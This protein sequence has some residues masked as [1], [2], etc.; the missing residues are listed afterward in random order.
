MIAAKEDL[1]H[2]QKLASDREALAAIAQQK[3]EAT[4]AIQRSEAAQAAQNVIQAQQRLAAS[5]AAVA[6]HQKI[7]ASIEIQRTENEAAKLSKLQRNEE[8]AALHHVTASKY[9][10][11][12]S[13]INRV[14][15]PQFP[16]NPWT[17]QPIHSIHGWPNPPPASNIWNPAKPTLLWG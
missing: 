13:G 3:S 15:T 8:A 14:N 16:P 11:L 12:N 5:K 1:I 4:A 17:Q 9:A 10:A 7:A 2:Q 6:H